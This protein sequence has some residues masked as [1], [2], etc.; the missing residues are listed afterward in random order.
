MPKQKKNY[1]AGFCLLCLLNNQTSLG[2]MART[3]GFFGRLLCRMAEAGITLSD[4][5]ALEEGIVLFATDDPEA[6][7]LLEVFQGGSD[8]HESDA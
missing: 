5:K 8:E 3:L 4:P 6:A 7:K 2:H 1:E